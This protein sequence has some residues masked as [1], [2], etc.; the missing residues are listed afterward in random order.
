MKLRRT[1][2]GLAVVLVVSGAAFAQTSGENPFQKNRGTAPAPTVAAA[3]Q[4][5]AAPPEGAGSGG[6]DFG[7]WRGASA[8]SYGPSFER[9]VQAHVTGKPVSAIRTALQA[10]GFTCI[11]ARE[12]GGVGPALECRLAARDGAC[13]VEW[14]SVVEDPLAPPKAGWDRMCR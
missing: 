2:A 7:A 11:E 13:G 1:I 10:D 4:V 3:E 6:L 14:W 12:R 5:T 8:Q 9:R